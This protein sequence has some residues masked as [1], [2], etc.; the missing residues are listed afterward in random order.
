MVGMGRLIGAE[1]IVIPGKPAT[2]ICP[3]GASTDIGPVPALKP[4]VIEPGQAI[5]GRHAARGLPEARSGFRRGCNFLRLG[6]L[7][8]DQRARKDQFGREPQG[9]G[10]HKWYLKA[11]L[12]LPLAL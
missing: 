6:P 5:D 3:P 1:Y 7:A 8:E 11:G 4:P 10:L 9:R 2:E 12:D